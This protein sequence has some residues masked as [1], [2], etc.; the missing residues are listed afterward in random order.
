MDRKPRSAAIA[1]GVGMSAVTQTSNIVINTVQASRRFR[2]TFIF[3]LKIKFKFASLPSIS[4]QNP[5]TTISQQIIAA[6]AA[7]LAGINCV[8]TWS[9]RS[10][11]QVMLL[12][13]VVS[14]IGEHWSP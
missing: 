11:P 9:I 12:K 1:L 13:I 3:Q 14:E 5:I 8:L 6:T 7:M 2:I 4:Q 10:A